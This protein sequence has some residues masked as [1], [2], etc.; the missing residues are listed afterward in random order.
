M[1]SDNFSEETPYFDLKEGSFAPINPAHQ[2]WLESDLSELFNQFLH[3]PK[4]QSHGIKMNRDQR[5]NLLRHMLDYY[6]LHIENFPTINSLEILEEV[7][8]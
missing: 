4:E 3:L 8:G 6:Q 1:P 5:R 2:Y 7:M